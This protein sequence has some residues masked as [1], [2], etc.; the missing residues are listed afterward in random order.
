[1]YVKCR[2]IC[3]IKN[4]TLQHD[5][6]KICVYKKNPLYIILLYIYIL[7]ILCT[8]GYIHRYF[9]N[10]SY[11]Y[12][13]RKIDW[14][15]IPLMISILSFRIYAWL[16]QNYI[17]YSITIISINKYEQKKT[18]ILC[19][20]Y[21]IMDGFVS[22]IKTQCVPDVAVPNIIIAGSWL[23]A[24]PTG[25]HS[26]TLYYIIFLSLW[27]LYYIWMNWVIYWIVS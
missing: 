4:H 20:R 16:N 1:M 22:F 9:I 10:I 13:T 25:Y 19:I 2:H 11:S 6:T 26:V 18:V 27:W 3:L 8:H 14:K 5:T 7:I 17:Q 24:W 15:T 12:Y 23:R 21:G